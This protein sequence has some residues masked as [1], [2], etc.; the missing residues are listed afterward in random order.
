MKT[1][2]LV[3]FFIAFACV[4]PFAAQSTPLHIKP[5]AW[6]DKTTVTTSGAQNMIPAEVLKSM[7]PERRKMLLNPAPVTMTDKHCVKDSDTIDSTFKQHDSNMKCEMKNV[8]QSSTSYE[9]DVAC[10]HPGHG[11]KEVSFT[12]HLK[13]KAESAE[14]VFSTADM[15]AST[16]TKSHTE[17]TSHWIKAS[18]DGITA[19]PYK[20]KQ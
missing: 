2:K 8:K 1:T 10:S 18:C 9:A 4:I 16:G 11:G 13:V 12:S 19:H 5:G 15:E 3:R 7:P 17:T 20:G 6:E 14:K